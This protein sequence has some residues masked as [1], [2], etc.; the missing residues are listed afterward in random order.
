MYN[1]LERQADEFAY[2][3]SGM[4]RGVTITFAPHT[5]SNKSFYALKEG[6]INDLGTVKE[7]GDTR[8]LEYINGA[9]PAT[10]MTL[11]SM[12]SVSDPT[13][14]Y[15]YNR[16]RATVGDTIELTSQTYRN[17]TYTI[18]IRMGTT[19]GFQADAQDAIQVYGQWNGT[20]LSL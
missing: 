15:L 17:S 13:N 2:L 5:N 14:H 4:M 8:V 20:N 10:G 7:D 18:F 16:V 9:A 6:K 19:G 11:S 1:D 12:A 3:A